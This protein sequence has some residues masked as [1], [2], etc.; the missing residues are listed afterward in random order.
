MAAWIHTFRRI[1]G[2]RPEGSVPTVRSNVCS[3]RYHVAVMWCT[4]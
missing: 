1:L 4:C 3:R 2:Q